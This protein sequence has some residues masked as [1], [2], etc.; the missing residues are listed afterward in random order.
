MPE[1][2]E[3]RDRRATLERAALQVSQV[4]LVLVARKV[5]KVSLDRLASLEQVAFRVPR[6]RREP[7][8]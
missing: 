5:S 6:A 3:P 1:H 2:K 8:A 4:S 7:R